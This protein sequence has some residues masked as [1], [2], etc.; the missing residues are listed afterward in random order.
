MGSF[1]RTGAL[2]DIMP[3]LLD[4]VYCWIFARRVFRRWNLSLFRLGLRGLGVLNFE[5]GINGER[6]FITEILPRLVPRERAVFCDVGANVGKYSLMLRARFPEAE[7]HAFEPHPQNFAKLRTEG[8]AHRWKC[9]QTAVG[10]TVGEITLF[11]RADFEG[12]THASLHPEVI[13][14]IHKQELR[15]W[16][17]AVETLDT[18]ATREQIA[19]IDFL[20]IDTEGNG[21]AVLQGAAQLLAQNRIGCIQFEFN[22]MEVISRVFLRDYRQF[23]AGFQLYRLLP[24]GL[25]KL[26]ETP[27]LTELFGYQN[28]I[29]LP[30]SVAHNF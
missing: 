23:L 16:R 8:T 6:S 4:R 28:I 1:L 29:A 30:Q 3:R 17:V 5:D 10:K 25:L 19:R 20:K 22:E 14:E 7:I 11:D 9:Y 18:F 27:I 13:T 15:S 2:E 12:S 21:L 24:R 26:D